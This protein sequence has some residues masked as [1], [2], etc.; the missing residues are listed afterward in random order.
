MGLRISCV[1]FEKGRLFCEEEDFCFLDC[2]FVA[3]GGEP[4]SRAL[5]EVAGGR[6][7]VCLAQLDGKSFLVFSWSLD[8][9]V[10]AF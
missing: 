3:G 7:L 8:D 1:F 5:Q 6:A 10:A 9:C 4:G 2:L